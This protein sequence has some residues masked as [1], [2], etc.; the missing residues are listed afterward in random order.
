MKKFI[1]LFALLLAFLSSYPNVAQPG[2]WDAGG[3]GSFSLL[4]EGDSVGY[5]QIRMAKELVAVQLFN[6]F[7]V[8]RGEYWMY[9]TTRDSLLIR[10]GYPLNTSFDAD[11][12]GKRTSIFFDSLSAL[13]VMIDGKEIALNEVR[14]I[15]DS[16]TDGNINKWY[17]WNCLFK[18]ADTTRIVVYFLVNTNNAGIRE[19]YVNDKNNAFIYLLET[20]AIWKNP[21]GHGTF[22]VQLMDELDEDDIH[23]ADPTSIFKFDEDARILFYEFTDL[24]PSSINNI[25]LNYSKRQ[26][27]FDFSGISK[28]SADY[29]RSSDELASINISELKLKEISFGSAYDAKGFSFMTLI[30]IVVAVVG[31]MIATGVIIGLVK[32]V[33][34]IRKKRS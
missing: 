20:G 6:G 4:Y 34:S 21:I 1:L 9:N 8:V 12:N 5:K 24:T 13:K 15:S 11:K 22:L 14:D 28:N 26:K 29:F 17:V 18:P 7:A 33:K 3:S 30:L 32:I 23:G 2:I 25:I 27:D 31:L 10:V 19:G 16:R